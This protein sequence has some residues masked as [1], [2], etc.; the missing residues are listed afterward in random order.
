MA[1]EPEKH[2]NRRS[3]LRTGAVVTGVAWATPVLTAIGVSSA[4]ADTPSGAT[5]PP[6]PP[7]PT[8][9]VLG[10]SVTRSSTTA[11]TSTV[12]ASGEELPRTGNNTVPLLATGAALVAGGLVMRKAAAEP[13]QDTQN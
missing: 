13:E 1:G 10:R 11:S 7:P 3:A 4:H 5:P 9:E 6:P 8:T 12:Q 2:I